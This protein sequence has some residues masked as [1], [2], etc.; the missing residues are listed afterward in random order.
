MN[1]SGNIDHVDD[2]KLTK[3][4]SIDELADALRISSHSVRNF[5]NPNSR[6][7]SPEFP[8]PIAIGRQKLFI[9]QE[10]LDYLQGL[11]AERT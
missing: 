8:K 1:K 7:F 9:K 3:L 6:H 2:A 5:I 4:I 11:K 10:V